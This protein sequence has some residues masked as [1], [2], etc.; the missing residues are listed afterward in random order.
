MMV[1]VFWCWDL[2]A[3]HLKCVCIYKKNQTLQA[4]ECPSKNSAPLRY[5]LTPAGSAVIFINTNPVCW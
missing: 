2:A 3:L 1:L 5:S 4:I